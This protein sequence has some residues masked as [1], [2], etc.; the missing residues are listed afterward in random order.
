MPTYFFVLAFSTLILS[1]IN[2][3]AQSESILAEIP[4]ALFVTWYFHFLTMH[5]HV[6][7]TTV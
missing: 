2:V 5:Y 6:L 1:V 7:Y 3:Q 4:Y